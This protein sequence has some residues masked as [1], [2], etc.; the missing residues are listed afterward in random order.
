MLD[1]QKPLNFKIV[2]FNYSEFFIDHVFETVVMFVFWFSSYF[3]SL[4]IY[5]FTILKISFDGLS[6]GFSIGNAAAAP[7]LSVNKCKALWIHW[8]LG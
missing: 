4:H 2:S 7:D 5:F 3:P 8:Q 6:L 1:V